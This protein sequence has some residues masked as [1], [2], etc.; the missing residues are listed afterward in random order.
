M[1]LPVLSDQYLRSF[2]LGFT[3]RTRVL[4]TLEAKSFFAEVARCQLEMI[5]VVSGDLA[6]VIAS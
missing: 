2:P 5:A 1:Y 3:F 6:A 4:S